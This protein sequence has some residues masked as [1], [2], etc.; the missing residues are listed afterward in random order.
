MIQ[1]STRRL[2]GP[3]DPIS[4][5]V[6]LVWRNDCQVVVVGRDECV[7]SGEVGLFCACEVW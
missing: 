2:L 3:V 1:N 7:D 4:L 6:E 5:G